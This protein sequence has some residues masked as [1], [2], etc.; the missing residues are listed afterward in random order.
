[1]NRNLSHRLMLFVMLLICSMSSG[2]VDAQSQQDSKPAKSDAKPKL[3]VLLIDGQNNHSIW[4]KTSEMMRKFLLE[5]ELFSVELARTAPKG[6]DE[7]FKPKFADFDV[8]LSNYNGD[9]WPVETQKSLESFIENGGGMVVVHA[10]DNAFPEWQAWNQMI[11]LGGWGGRNA[12]S[13]PYVYFDDQNKIVHNTDEGAGGSHGSQHEFSIVTRDADHPI[14]K[15]FP[16]KWLHTKDEL[17]DR[18]RGPAKNMKVLATAFSSKDQGGTGRNEPM[19]MAVEFGKGRVVH[20]TLGHADYSQE[21]VGFITLLQRGAEWAAI[22]KVTQ[23]LP[24]DFPTAD[25]I[26]ARAYTDEK[27]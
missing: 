11:G 19:V 22:G 5:T 27:K 15:D 10:A 26:S 3:R 6:T 16:E 8:V 20:T 12:Q 7:N 23:A 13:G 17:Y 18:L 25:A 9:N 1:M 21:C 14:M 2:A 24:K 4:P